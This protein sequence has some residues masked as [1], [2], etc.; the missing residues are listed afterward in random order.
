MSGRDAG[1]D[2]LSTVNRILQ[3]RMVDEE[4]EK[5]KQ[6]YTGAGV[7]E[8][9][10]AIGEGL[11]RSVMGGLA[12]IGAAAIPGGKSGPEMVESFTKGSYVP[13]TESGQ[14]S[15]ERLGDLAQYG[16]DIARFPISGIGGLIELL[17]GQGV[18]QAANTVRSVQE[19]GA[20][21]TAGDRVMEETGS[22]FLATAARIAPEGIAE[23]AGLKGGGRALKST[24]STT[25]QLVEAGK[26]LFPIQTPAR[27]RIAGMLED[28]SSD[29]QTAGYRLHPPRKPELLERAADEAAGL[30]ATIARPKAAPDPFQREAIR[31][32]FDEGIVA[33]IREASPADRAKMLQMTDT[34]ER[35]KANSRFS[36]ENRPSDIAG[37]SALERFNLVVQKNREAGSQLDAAANKLR[38]QPID[39][40]S[41]VNTFMDDLDSIGVQISDDLQPIFKGSDVEGLSAPEGVIK[42]LVTRMAES[43]PIDAYE[44]HRLKR[45]IDE[46]VSFGKSGD[47][48]AG[49]TEVILKNLRRNLDQTLDGAFPEYDRIN[50]QYAD[51]INVINDMQSSMGRKV[52]LSGANSNKAV[53]TSLRRLLS[54]AQGRQEM[55]NVLNE[56][57]SV[58]RKYGGKFDDDLLNQVLFADELDN[59]LGPVARTSFQGQIA[60]AIPKTQAGVIDKVAD[61][62]LSWGA[63]KVRGIN[64]QNQFK[65]MRDLLNSF[66]D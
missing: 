45:F 46:N 12:G 29:R 10:R 17:S 33:T 8:P 15:M 18:D 3:K 39:A 60:Q 37:N 38:G 56:M 61:A 7:V 42:R 53:G 48:L 47:G 14:K 49:R 9:A 34:M 26:D 20:G 62:A 50:T 32:G 43:G 31:Q 40:T 19:R 55:L 13:E 65:S 5:R 58:A 35:G 59:V 54:N 30:P 22:P 6:D 36:A 24:A 25:G 23:V 4:I 27:Q 63:E 52:D 57:D 41:A 11:A 1:G 66:E 2:Q 28:G 44:L 51:T 21:V 64:P 16:I